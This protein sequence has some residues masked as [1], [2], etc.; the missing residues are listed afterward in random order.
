MKLIIFRT[1]FRCPLIGGI[2]ACNYS[3]GIK[4]SSKRH[5]H[6]GGS[7]RRC[8]CYR[9][10]SRDCRRRYRRG[11]SKC[12]STGVLCAQYF[13]EGAVCGQCIVDTHTRIRD[14]RWG[15]GSNTRHLAHTGDGLRVQ[16]TCERFIIILINAG[17]CARCSITSEGCIGELRRVL[18]VVSRIRHVQKRDTASLLSE[19]AIEHSAL[20]SL[21]ERCTTAAKCDDSDRLSRHI[22]ARNI[23]DRIICRIQDIGS[24]YSASRCRARIRRD[25]CRIRNSC[26]LRIG[27][28]QLRKSTRDNRVVARKIFIDLD[29][30]T[31]WV[32]SIRER[33]LHLTGTSRKIR[34]K[35]RHIH[36]QYDRSIYRRG[37]S[38]GHSRCYARR[39]S[40]GRLRRN[41]ICSRGIRSCRRRSVG[42]RRCIRRCKL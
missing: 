31:T 12:A 41:K 5:G 16:S 3:V 19:L 15:A 30:P 20:E 37:G 35:L 9:Y 2:G 14:D 40:A 22:D 26:K 17:I 7:R 13:C 36:R 6:G 25:H 39:L 38:G 4:R 8:R 24:Q 1:K 32:V 27:L 10:R 18:C 34:R 29:R 33:H 21:F 11:R 42:F 28:A 23:F